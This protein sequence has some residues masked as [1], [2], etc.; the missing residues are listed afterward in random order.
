MNTPQKMK[1]IDPKTHPKVMP[2]NVGESMN[3]KIALINHRK[4]ENMLES[5]VSLSRAMQLKTIA[6]P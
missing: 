5:I 4:A 3:V 2:I 1:L 6:V